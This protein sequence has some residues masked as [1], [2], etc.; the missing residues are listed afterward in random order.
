[1][2]ES[3]RT[4][5]RVWKNLRMVKTGMDTQRVSPREVAISS[6]DI[7]ISETSNSAKRSWRQNISEGC[8]IVGTS[9]MPCGLTRPSRM[10]RVR[11]LSESAML[12]SRWVAC[13]PNQ[14]GWSKFERRTSAAHSRVSGNPGPTALRSG[15]PLSRGRADHALSFACG[16]IL[17]RARQGHVDAVV[18]HAHINGAQAVFGVAAVAAGFD[19]EFPA[20]PGADDVLLLGEAQAAAGL[21]RRQIFLDA[22]DHLALADRAAVMGTII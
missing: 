16:R 1:M 22:R 18:V 21:V 17:S 4:M 15:S 5:M 14:V 10:G 11:S 19:V 7:D 6:E 12:S 8:T 13:M 2:P 9:V 20:V 3:G